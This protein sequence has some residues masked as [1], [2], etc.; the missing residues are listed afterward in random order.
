M[1]E[2]NLGS[3]EI[4]IPMRCQCFGRVKIFTAPRTSPGV[5]IHLLQRVY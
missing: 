1:A 5:A 2:I 4:D 3:D